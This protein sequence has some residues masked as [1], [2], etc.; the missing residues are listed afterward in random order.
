MKKIAC[1]LGALVLTGCSDEVWDPVTFSC[2]SSGEETAHPGFE[3]LFHFSGGYLF[4]QSDDG[5][6]DNICNLAGTVDCSVKMTRDA[7]TVRQT[8]EEP[9]CGYRSTARTNLDIDRESGSFRLLQEGCDPQDD[10]IITGTCQSIA[11][12]PD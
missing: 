5:G 6:A 12:A 7:L 1:L 4:L 8:V 9:Y 11:A 2:I 10:R 3:V